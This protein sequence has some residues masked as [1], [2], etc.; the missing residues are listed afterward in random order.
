MKFIFLSYPFLFCSAPCEQ[1]T[2][3]ACLQ[4][5]FHNNTLKKGGDGLEFAEDWYQPKGCYAYSSGR[6]KDR[7]YYGRGGTKD[8][9]SNTKIGGSKYRPPGYDCKIAMKG[10]EYSSKAYE[11]SNFRK[12]M[13]GG[14]KGHG[15]VP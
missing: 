7:V 3:D 5:V 4:A 12:G 10:I 8:Q 6:R 2:E 14:I 11:Y 1:Y 13:R 9:K 15:W